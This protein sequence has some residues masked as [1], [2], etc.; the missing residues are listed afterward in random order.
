MQQMYYSSAKSGGAMK[1]RT[2]GMLLGALCVFT[3]LG[4]AQE[5]FEFPKNGSG[6]L[7]F[8]TAALN[9]A[10][11]PSPSSHPFL[12]GT[13]AGWCAGHL[14][15][16]RFMIVFWQIQVANTIAL[17]AGVENSSGEELKNVMTTS[18]DNTCIPD[19]VDSLQMTR[20][21]VKW[22]RDHPERLHENP[23]LLTLDAFHDAFPCHAPAAKKPNP[24]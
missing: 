4:S 23:D 3:V 7:E 11:S 14:Q 19:E 21:L 1:L 22:L 10:D 24:K 12:E 8:C 20:V 15:T 5:S 2:T 16:M 18:S 13:K 6:V 17:S 9:A